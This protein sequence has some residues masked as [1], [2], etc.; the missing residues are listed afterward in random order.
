MGRKTHAYTD[1]TTLE[2]FKEDL[3]AYPQYV[4]KGFL[5]LSTLQKSLQ[6]F[7]DMDDQTTKRFFDY[8]HHVDKKMSCPGTANGNRFHKVP[9]LLTGAVYLT[10]YPETVSQLD[11]DELMHL[12][13]FS[14][15]EPLA[16]YETATATWTKDLLGTLSSLSDDYMQVFSYMEYADH[17]LETGS[18]PE[19]VTT[20]LKETPVEALKQ[21]TMDYE[22]KEFEKGALY[23]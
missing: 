2:G 8:L 13:R 7:N 18:S 5:P 6:S 10:Y 16:F 19:E 3:V 23:L 15:P 22:T 1:I 12:S 11:N 17:K 9:V 21:E 4:D 14:I 20:Y